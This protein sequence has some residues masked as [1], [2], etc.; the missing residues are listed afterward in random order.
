MVSTSQGNPFWNSGFLSHSH[1]TMKVLLVLLETSAQF[2]RLG[3]GPTRLTGF[4]LR[5][6][7]KWADPNSLPTKIA[8]SGCTSGLPFLWTRRGEWRGST[9]NQAHIVLRICASCFWCNGFSMG[10]RK[11]V[12]EGR[13]WGEWSVPSCRPVLERFV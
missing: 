10:C 5:C 1:M 4:D 7:L 12:K 11:E 13:S 8:K 9:K 3:A 2:A 6:S